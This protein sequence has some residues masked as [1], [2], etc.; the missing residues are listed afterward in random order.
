MDM[1]ERLVADTDKRTTPYPRYHLAALYA[2]SAA[3]LLFIFFFDLAIPPGIAVGVLYAVVVLL[4]LWIPHDKATL[5]FSLISSFLII[6]A[7]FYKAPAEEMWKAG[8]NRGIALF[9]VWII[10]SLGLKRRQMEQ[11]RNAILR[12]REKALDEIKILRGLLPI[13]ASCKRI[14]D[15][16]GDWSQIEGYIKSH[17]EAEFTHGICPEC[18]ERLYPDFFKKSDF[19]RKK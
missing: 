19:Y 18:A 11:Q 8:Y 9:T 2:A 12:E 6:A 3:F 5:A 10:A 4:S 14:K 17:S 16:N 7:F 13:C 1:N 15:D